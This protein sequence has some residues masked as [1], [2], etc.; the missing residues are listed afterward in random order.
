MLLLLILM[1]LV[2]VVLRRSAEGRV[3]VTA[4]VTFNPTVAHARESDTVAF[5]LVDRSD[6]ARGAHA[7]DVPGVVQPLL[8][9]SVAN[10]I[11]AP[12]A[13]GAVRP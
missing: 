8:E 5:M 10:D 13:D 12:L 11:R 2:T 9:W 6:A 3:T 7:Q 1:R 4:A